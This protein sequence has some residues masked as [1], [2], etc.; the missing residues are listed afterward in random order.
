MAILTESKIRKLLKTT[1]LKE[2]KTLRLEP[3]T[4][5]TPSAKG[6]LNDITVIYGSQVE[7]P[8]TPASVEPV[9]NHTEQPSKNHF[10]QINRLGHEVVH[11]HFSFQ[12]NI[13][14]EKVISTIL[15]GQHVSYAH[16]QTGLIAD[17]DNLL[18][19]LQDFRKLVF[20]GNYWERFHIEEEAFEQEVEQR[21][22]LFSQHSFIPKYSDGELVLM[23]YRLYIEVRELE[24]HASSC[25]QPYLLYDEYCSLMEQFLFMKEYVWVLMIREIDGRNKGG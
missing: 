12:W 6:Y 18:Q 3:G 4:I 21:N 20:R 24:L 1:D 2:T 22:Q 8:P 11:N 19:M 5:I 25:L 17:L 16:Q 15:E 23:L 14:V 7:E 13:K 9:N 10:R